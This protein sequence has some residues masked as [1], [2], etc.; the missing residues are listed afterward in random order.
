[1]KKKKTH[2][3]T[4]SAFNRNC[5]V[6]GTKREKMNNARMESLMNKLAGFTK[7]VKAMKEDNTE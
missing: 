7:N 1:V 5:D 2:V 4:G 3:K 6:K